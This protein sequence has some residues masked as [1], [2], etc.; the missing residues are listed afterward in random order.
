MEHRHTWIVGAGLAGSLLASL[1]AKQAH[2]VT[3]S[4]RR[5]SVELEQLAAG[6]SI[7]LA[8]AERGRYALELA[9]VADQVLAQAVAMPG[10]QVHLADGTQNF[11][12]YA[13]DLQQSIY[14]VHRARMNRTLLNAAKANGATM[15]FDERVV[16]IDLH[17]RR[18]IVQVGTRQNEVQFDFVIGADGAGSVLRDAI[19]SMHAASASHTNA[20]S[21]R[22]PYFDT[23]DHSYKELSIPPN[24]DGSYQLNANALHIW[25]RESFMLIALPNPD[26]SFT[27]TLF[28][29]NQ[30]TPSF[31]SIQDQASAR[32]LFEKE[33]ATAASLMPDYLSD[34]QDNPQGVLG[35]LRCQQWYWRDRAVILG[36]AAH[37]IVPFHGQGM[38]C[39]F[40]DCVVLADLLQNPASVASAPL[41][42]VF[43]QFQSQRQPEAHA[44]AEMALE[45]YIEMRDL[46]ADEDYRLRKKLEQLLAKRHPGWFVPRYELVSFSRYGYALARQRGQI[47]SAIVHDL[48]KGKTALEQ[49]DLVQADQW[50]AE[51]L[52]PLPVQS[53][54]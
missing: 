38:N 54:Y 23:L 49:I 31:A 32:C 6:R 44:I 16:S 20:G 14:S 46:V 37:A 40:E 35:T 34:L 42:Q 5:S 33:F 25:P 11:Q 29:Q 22:P 3:V 21:V 24:A 17:R 52:P 9:G 30:G 12:P 51:K 18:A 45:N 4:E 41:E 27:A 1:L 15:F 48:C 19:A 39:A 13:A 10:R 43:R 47:Q 7:N 26:A 36:D 2:K 50:I 8:L 28:L 53:H